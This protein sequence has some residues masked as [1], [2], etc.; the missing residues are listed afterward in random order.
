MRILF[1]L[2]CFALIHCV[3]G[4]QSNPFDIGMQSPSVKADS[5]KQ[6]RQANLRQSSSSDNPFDILGT[7]SYSS[8]NTSLDETTLADV[9]NQPKSN[10]LLVLIYTLVSLSLLTFAISINRSKFISILK[11][12]Y[13]SIYLKALYKEGRKWFDLQSIIL[14]GLFF[15]NAGFLLWLINDHYF[16]GKLPNVFVLTF[17]ILGVYIIRHWIMWVIAYL[18]QLPSE[19]GVYSFSIG[20]HNM[21]LGIILIPFIIAIGFLPMSQHRILLA[22][23]VCFVLV[24]Y[25]F[26]QIKGVLSILMARE[27][28]VFYFFIYLCAI[29]IAPILIAWKLV[30]GAL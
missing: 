6:Q 11:T 23:L 20:T 9:P 1:I 27:F 16:Y 22:I 3:S 8:N 4:Q 13:N 19:V 14:Y 25:L 29:E 18:Y 5:T 28:N 17:A 10:D 15:T 2:F 12:F 7:Q 21:I 30:S 26:R 24:V